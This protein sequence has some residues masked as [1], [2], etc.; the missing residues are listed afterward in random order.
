MF[1]V[2]HGYVGPDHYDCS[3]GDP[4][5]QLTEFLTADAVTKFRQEFEEA[6]PRNASNARFRVIEG[7]ERKVSLA[8]TVTSWKL[9]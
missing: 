8:T 7:R 6:L 5:Y 2:Y 1:F 3:E 9:T 4:L